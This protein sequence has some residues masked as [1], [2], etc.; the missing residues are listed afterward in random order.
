MVI[1]YFCIQQQGGTHAIPKQ[2]PHDYH[3]TYRNSKER[4][5]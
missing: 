1:Q 4:N 3:F 5:N 2:T